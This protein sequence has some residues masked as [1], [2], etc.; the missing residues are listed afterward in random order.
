MNYL[1]LLN[2]AII[3]D[4]T[5]LVLI[6][7]GVIQSTSIKEWYNNFSLG[8]FISDI[9]SI[10][11]GVMLAYFIYPYIFSEFKI[12]NF[13]AI[14]VDIQ[15]IHDILL[16]M[17]IK[18]IPIGNSKIIDIFKKYSEEHSLKILGVDAIMMIS[19]ILIY[20]YLFDKSIDINMFILIT[21]LYLL[22]YFLYSI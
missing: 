13:I 2:S 1:A 9:F 15:L 5:V 4:L 20:T 10:M 3:T 8:A 6:I 11:F 16:G 17:L 14:T 21:S 18:V 22:P 12:I 19:T 7:F